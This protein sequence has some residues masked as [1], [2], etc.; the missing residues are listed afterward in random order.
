MSYP[1]PDEA[2]SQIADRLT[3]P[4]PAVHTPL[5]REHHARPLLLF[6]P[7]EWA[8][9]ALLSCVAL[10]P[11]LILARQLDVNTD[12]PIY[13]TAANWYML[14]LKQHYL[15]NTHWLYNYE[16]PAFAKLLMGLS[17]T[18]SQY[19]H[20]A[21]LLFPARLP[22]VVL[23][24]LLV[25]A[26]YVLG[27]SI[28]GRTVALL[29]ALSLAVSP[30]VVFFSSLALLDMTMTTLITLAALFLWYAPRHPRLYALCGVFIGLAGASKYPAAL[31]VPGMLLYVV[32][33][34]ACL[35]RSMP[36]CER[37][38]LPWGWWL[39]GLCLIPVSFFLADPSIWLD[40]FHR[41][42][43]SLQF[44]LSHADNGHATFWAGRTYEHVP[45]WMILYVLFAKVSAFVTIPAALFLVFTAVQLVRF[46][47]PRKMALSSAPEQVQKIAALAFLWIWLVTALLFYGRL[48]ILV[49]THYY[50]PLAEPLF[51]A[52]ATGL[53]LVVRTLACWLLPEPSSQQAPRIAP[54][55]AR[56]SFTWRSG[57]IFA[58]LAIAL[59]GPHLIGLLTIPDADGYT[60]EFFQGENSTLAVMYSGYHDADVWLMEHSKSGG[61]V[62]IV[63][64]S[65]I[66]LWYISNP[67]KAGNF[68]FTVV[69]YG[70][71]TT[72]FDYLVWPE[73]LIQRGWGPPAAWKAHT[74][75]L[76][77]GGS[78]T[79]CLIMARDPSTLH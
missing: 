60:S 41:L 75:H 72:A 18:L 17:I 63:G 46:H 20:A 26:V 1:F 24:T 31:A 33:Y 53:A 64:G 42:L 38:A 76:I 3:I 49:G 51:L 58:V 13:V 69:Q 73:S 45:F 10:L 54:V 2:E 29:A 67:H 62:G 23:G 66:G 44:S 79:Y 7:A 14:L 56:A 19:F 30:W 77:S 15:T 55:P 12:E 6:A 16:H 47:W 32:Y 61:T 43:T 28:F 25:V 35:R 50:L 52:G 22:S 40:P 39:L 57:L 4:L 34:Y 8:L 70:S 27:K 21:N 9:I 37:P 36:A 5:P 78:T 74:V 65:A 11:R 48:D 71:S 68:Q 59:V